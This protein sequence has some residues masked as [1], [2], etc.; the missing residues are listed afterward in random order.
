MQYFSLVLLPSE[1]DNGIRKK[2]ERYRNQE[3][4]LPGIGAILKKNIWG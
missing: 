1:P 4:R 3:S 2:S